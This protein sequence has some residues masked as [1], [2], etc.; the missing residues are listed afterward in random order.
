MSLSKTNASALILIDIQNGF[1][2]LPYWGAERNN[3]DAEK[4][5]SVLLNLCR[6]KDFPIF[7]VQHCSSDPSS[8]L[9]EK[10]KGNEFKD[11]VSPVG[12]ET[13]VEKDVNSAFIGT[14]LKK[15]LNDASIS[16]VV[17]V[18]LTTDHCIST[19]ARMA[20][21]YGFET[22]VIS[23]ASATFGKSGIDGS[24]FSAQLIHDTTL[25]S[26]NNEFASVVST[27]MIQQLI[28]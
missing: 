27:K 1:D 20:G 2:D 21:N 25:A 6:S 22:Y 3:L 5:T 18:G 7:H 15:L 19:T 28:N 8:V 10:H 26:L 11:I 16:K 14:N 13:I 4:N 23:D 12:E 24:F 9:N 17:I